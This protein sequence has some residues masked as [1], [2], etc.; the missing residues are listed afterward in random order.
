[1]KKIRIGTVGLGRLGRRHAENI[2]F[3]L[4]SAE[5]TAVCSIIPAEVDAVQQEWG[6]PYGYNDFAEMLKNQDLDAI[7]I[8][9]SS[10]EHCRQI[11]QAL[12]AG[13]HV[14]SEKPLGIG[15]EEVLSARQIVEKY[16]G[17]IFQLGFMRRFDPSYVYAKRKIEAGYIGKPVL[18]RCY[19]IDPVS[20]IDGAIAFAAKSGGLFLDMAIHDFDLSRWLLAAEAKSVY[21]VGACF[22]YKEFAKYG[23]VDN[24]AAMLQFQN[25]AM[26]LF[27]A[28]RMCAHGYHVETEVIGT[29][30]SLRIGTVPY[31][32]LVTLA[33][34]NGVTNE[35]VGGFLERFETAYLNEMEHFVNCIL[36]DKKPGVGVIDGVQS[37]AMAYAATESFHTGKVVYLD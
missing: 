15:M 32:N 37:T 27:Y 25:G 12:E 34:E 9:S 35:C 11:A 24:G 23:D 8:C 13:F 36:T 10:T 14:F 19:G 16:P 31:K 20:A 6:I 22:E 26:G 29:R 28:G 33:N 18:I 17:Q 5:L 7:S 2:A 4:P 1:M 21:A 30:G 3:R